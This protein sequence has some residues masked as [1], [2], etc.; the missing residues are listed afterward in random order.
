MGVADTGGTP[1]VVGVG[2]ILLIHKLYVLI[3]ITLTYWVQP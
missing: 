1:V 2:P 3:D